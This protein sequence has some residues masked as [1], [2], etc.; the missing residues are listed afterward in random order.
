[1]KRLISCFVLLLGLAGSI[2]ALEIRE[3][4]LKIAINEATG[5]FS[6]YYLTDI[7]KDRYLPLF[8]DKDPR[9]SFA[10]LLIDDRAHRLG[11]SSSFRTRVEK[12]E[13]GGRIVFE[14]SA[15]I[16]AQEFSFARLSGATLADTLKIEYVLSNKSERDLA[17][18]LRQVLDT[19]LAEKK[20]AH[21]RTDQRDI[22]SETTIIGS[23][24][25]RWWSTDGDEFGLMGSISIEGQNG[26][27]S[28]HFANWKRLNDAPW[29]AQASEGRNF[30]LLPYSIGDSAL[31]YYFEPTTIARGGERRVS[32]FLSIA[33]KSGFAGL[34]KTS[35]SALSDILQTS[36]QTAQSPDLALETDLITV[37]DL[38]VRID[39]AIKNPQ[40]V[41]DEELL[42]MEAIVSRL[43]A[44]NTAE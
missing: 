29:K 35:D 39:E 26:P 11:E 22:E 36:V 13:Q 10:A 34:E 1:M 5:R 2:A 42:A 18:G 6:L 20:S 44:R 15:L 3:G 25:D 32:I 9:T 24:G 41:S 43:K 30:N 38:L 4:R 23:A 14:S 37:R 27:D 19:N 7:Q 28:I 21:F 8:V 16:A 40:D 31:S 12:T 17:V 33:N